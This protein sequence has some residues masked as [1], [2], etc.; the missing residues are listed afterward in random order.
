MLDGQPF[1]DVPKNLG[2][3]VIGVG[4]LC[5]QKQFTHLIE[6]FSELSGEFPD[7]WLAILGEGDDH[8]KLA[9]KISDVGLADKIYLIG[10]VGNIGEWYKEAAMFVMTSRYEGYPNAL[11]EA[12]A[13]GTPDVSYDCPSG[14]AEVIQNN[15]NGLLV[16]ANNT[17]ELNQK[18]RA[19]M[20]DSDFAE[21][22]SKEAIQI[23]SVLN[24]NSVVEQW[25]SV[26]G[27]RFKSLE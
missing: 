4:R 9:M 10:R 12:M 23:R 20:R 18:M 21:K 25:L 3:M 26:A 15:V 19:I 5:P 22:I 14:P 17:D 7:W 6:A 8:D 13:S 11:I 1:V 27:L 2:R 16:A 24:T